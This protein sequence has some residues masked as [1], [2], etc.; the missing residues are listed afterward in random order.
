MS[1]LASEISD[2]QRTSDRL[3]RFNSMFR[4][5][6]TTVDLSSGSVESL[7]G[8]NINRWAITFLPDA[9]AGDQMQIAPYFIQEFDGVITL[10]TDGLFLKYK[11]HPL[12]VSGE[13]F[14][15]DPMF[16]GGSITVIEELVRL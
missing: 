14:G 13:R 9:T 16:A 10:Q 8:E 11:D 15:F 6:V 5:I 12:L 1:K 4:R 7:V 2:I 3:R